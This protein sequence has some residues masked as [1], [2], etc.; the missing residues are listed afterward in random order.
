MGTTPGAC[1][2]VSETSPPEKTSAGSGPPCG[3]IT[4]TSIAAGWCT[5]GGKLRLAGGSAFLAIPSLP[6]TPI[7]LLTP[8]VL[9]GP[10]DERPEEVDAALDDG[11]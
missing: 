4:S 8:R 2:T 11:L 3:G 9:I 1:P 5:G 10:P 6:G 7:L